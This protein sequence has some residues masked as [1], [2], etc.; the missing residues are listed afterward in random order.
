MKVFKFGG[1]TLSGEER[2]AKVLKIIAR[3]K[4]LGAVI[5]SALKGVTDALEEAG[6]RAVAGD[7]SSWQKTVKKI[8]DQH[9]GLIERFVFSD[10]KKLLLKK[11]E[12]QLGLLKRDLRKVDREG[13][14]TLED[15]D[16]VLAH[17]ECFSTLIMSFV[18]AEKGIAAHYLDGRD[19]ICTN[20]NFG[21]AAVF[22]RPTYTAMRKKIASLKSLPVITGYIAATK[23]G[24]TT[25]LGRDG[26][27]YTA[28]LVAA[29]LKADELVLWKDVDGVMTADPRKV[30][31]AFSI[32]GMTYDEAIELSNFGAT[33]VY[34]PTMQPVMA[35]EIPVRVKNVN[36]P[37]FA[38]TLIGL[39]PPRNRDRRFAIIGLSS[40]DNI[41]LLRVEGSGMVGVV[42]SA[43]RIFSAL[44]RKKINV[45]FISQAASEYSISLAVRP[46]S[47]LLAQKSLA[48]EFSPEIKKG[49]IKPIILETDLTSVAVVGENMKK[50]PLITSA[51]FSALEKNGVHVVAIAQGSS[52]LNVS[53]IVKKS[54]EMKSLNA[55]HDH[56]F[57]PCKRR[58]HLFIVGTGLI[59]S[60]LMAQILKQSPFLLENN[61]LEL[62]VVGLANRNKMLIAPDGV[63]LKNWS[64]LLAKAAPADIAVFV[65]EMQNLN[66]SNT[67]FV[68]C[69]AN[70]VLT[71]F[72]CELMCSGIAIVTPNKKA[73]S[74]DYAK[75]RKL[76]ESARLH[77]ARFLYE[78]NVGAGLPVIGTLN[79]L[80]ISGDKINSIEAILSGTLSY[81]F[82]NF[83]GRRVFSAVVREAQAKGY[84]EP[85]P[86][87]DLNG[88]DV[89]RKILILARECGYKLNLNDV[90][91][92]GFLPEAC[93]KA[94]TVAD[95]FRELEQ[96]DQLL[97]TKFKAAAKAG[98]KLRYIASLFD[99]KARVELKAVA[100]D[101]P[102]YEMRGSDNVV[103]FRTDRYATTPLVIKGPGAGA[104]VTAGGVLAD[105]I[106]LANL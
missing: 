48:K 17:G 60:T 72:Y 66:L 82:N 41:S 33:V 42:G 36:R 9:F 95:F 89:A 92:I 54:D 86:R 83:D 35:A 14:F 94:M 22:L 73:N 16:A 24:K 26:S 7:S 57:A 46:D 84:T 78:T 29:A 39:D 8:A 102:F 4:N 74:G 70:E 106:H 21:K 104:A 61:S 25:T 38:G 53:V 34:P 10:R 96:A 90:E 15:Q 44:E 76:K 69:T 79:D 6:W 3:E 12:A 43:M 18:L 93:F 71:D 45:V 98:K 100:A 13:K 67:V 97:A 56:F 5:F 31:D 85:D 62:R 91:V 88:M 75:Y 65:Q 28:A 1:S 23:D 55:L 30:E 47:A 50:S 37:D 103:S 105:I 40:I 2:I 59:G 32:A 63:K 81:I 87:D 52:E 80:L 64:S 58:L 77:G 19:L 27:D 49:V 51:L 20:N 99:G 68:D 11:I 101:H